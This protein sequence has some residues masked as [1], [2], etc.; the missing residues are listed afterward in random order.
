MKQRH[1]RPDVHT[2][3]AL[4]LPLLRAIE[5]G[6]KRISLTGGS[7]PLREEAK[8]GVLRG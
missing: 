7:M 1:Q 6:A 5:Q 2:S 3:T 8:T 4:V